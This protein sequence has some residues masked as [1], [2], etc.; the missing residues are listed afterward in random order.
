[1]AL[2]TWVEREGL[3]RS[4]ED[5]EK[6]RTELAQMLAERTLRTE[7]NG[8]DSGYVDCLRN[9][10]KAAEA[11]K[12]ELEVY[13][14]QFKKDEHPKGDDL[15]DAAFAVVGNSP[16]EKL[17]ESQARILRFHELKLAMAPYPDIVKAIDLE[18]AK[19]REMVSVTGFKTFDVE[20]IEERITTQMVFA[21]TPK[22]AIR[23]ALFKDGIVIDVDDSSTAKREPRVYQGGRRITQTEL[24]ADE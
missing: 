16:E 20:I 8:E 18:I 5:V 17:K 13:D 1:M 24:D 14:A 4:K 10:L 21:K 23:K 19:L 11:S 6:L 15:M 12:L 9:A 3:R 22:E 7:R 2:R